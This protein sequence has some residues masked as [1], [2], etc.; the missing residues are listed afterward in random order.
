VPKRF[1]RFSD[2]AG[3]K[4]HNLD[5]TLVNCDLVVKDLAPATEK[6]SYVY[7]ILRLWDE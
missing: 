6:K 7:I 5:E 1:P 3:A 2:P 4:G